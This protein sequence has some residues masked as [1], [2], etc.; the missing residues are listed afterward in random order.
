MEPASTWNT[1]V[2]LGAAIEVGR[3]RAGEQAAPRSKR[4]GVVWGGATATPGGR[5]E[6]GSQ[7]SGVHLT[8]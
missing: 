6:N 4:A 1:D 2:Y 5:A 8:L 3:R 7:R